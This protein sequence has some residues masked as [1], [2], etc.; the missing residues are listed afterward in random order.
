SVDIKIDAFIP[1]TYIEDEVQKIEVYK[2]IA[3]ISSYEDMM[4][5]IEEL[6]DRFSD[7]PYSVTNLM[8]ISYIRSLGKKLEIEEIKEAGDE[9][10]L[11]FDSV[12]SIDQKL[13]KSVIDKYSK[14]IV[15]RYGEKPVIACK[16][17]VIKRGNIIEFL[18]EFL[19]FMIDN[20]KTEKDHIR[21][22]NGIEKN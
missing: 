15:F 8:D 10:V 19:K 7:I 11:K 16:L 14:Q 2:K 13:F 9:L 21:E 3:S 18:E 5:I 4:D 22:E 17:N 6:V 20:N 12:E 1:E